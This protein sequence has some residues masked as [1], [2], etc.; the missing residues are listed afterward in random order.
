MLIGADSFSRRN[1]DLCP[2][3]PKISRLWHSLR[4]I[5][6][7]S[8]KSF[9]SGF[10]F[11]RA[12]ISTNAP[13]HTHHDKHI[14]MSAP[15]MILRLRHTRTL[16]LSWTVSAINQSWICWRTDC[17]C[18]VL[19]HYLLDTFIITFYFGCTANVNVSVLQN[20]SCCLTNFVNVH[21]SVLTCHRRCCQNKC[22]TFFFIHA[23]QY[24][25][26]SNKMWTVL[27]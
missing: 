15:I 14:T 5:T 26:I 16:S 25:C 3:V 20:V 11:Y 10:S 1:P 24:S 21:L 4:T 2:F 22:N 17:L 12:N 7:L 13:Q 9:Q 6:V 27:F 18:S 8:F 23:Y 19:H